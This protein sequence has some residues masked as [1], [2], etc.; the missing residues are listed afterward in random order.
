M[1]LKKGANIAR[2][3]N[4]IA[5][6]GSTGI[7]RGGSAGADQQRLDLHGLEKQQRIAQEF[8]VLQHSGLVYAHSAF[9]SLQLA[10]GNRSGYASRG[11][12]HAQPPVES[13]LD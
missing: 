5:Q 8:F 4:L 6:M 2:L 13:R 10:P 7:S 9:L 12:G 11:A 1:R 3:F